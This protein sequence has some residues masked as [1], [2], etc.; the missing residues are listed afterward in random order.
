M[1]ATEPPKPKRRSSTPVR[2]HHSRTC[3][4]AGRWGGAR[5]R[6][7]GRRS[8]AAAATAGAAAGAVG[9]CT[10]HA[11]HMHGMRM[12]RTWPSLSP[13]ATHRPHGEVQSK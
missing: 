4:G 12:V 9:T 7:R 6:R 1:A 3:G 2:A 10:A 13:E 11:W 5:A 8:E